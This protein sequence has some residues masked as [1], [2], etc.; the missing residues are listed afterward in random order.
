M[1]GYCVERPTV[2][3]VLA[4]MAASVPAAANASERVAM[5][6]TAKIVANSNAERSPSSRTKL[7]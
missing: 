4:S 3:I 7:P 2:A 5:R 6:S 1:L